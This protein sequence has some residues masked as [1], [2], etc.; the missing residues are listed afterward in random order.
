MGERYMNMALELAL[1]GKCSTSP[2]P[3][4]GAVIVKDG[5]IIGKG[6][7]EKCGGNHAEINAIESATESV[8]GSTI[9]VT[10]EP[11]SHHGK[12]PPCADRIIKEKFAKVVIASLD[13][14]PLVAG[15]G[16]KK[17][18]DA[19]IV[20]ET[21][22]LDEESRTINEVF[23]KYIIEKEPFVLMKGAMSLDGK[24]ATCTGESKWISGEKSREE[25]QELRRFMTGIMVGIGT[26]LAD[27]PELTCRI[28]GAKSPIRIIVDSNLR[29][30]MESKVLK[31]QKQ[32]KTIIASLKEKADSEKINK[33]K[34]IGIEVLLLES[35]SG[36][37]D[38]RELMKELG[39]RE[40]DSI[41]LEGGG[42][43]NFSAIEA[44]IVDKVI[45]YVAPIIIGGDDSKTPVGGQGFIQLKDA[46]KLKEISVSKIGEDIKI[47]GYP[48]RR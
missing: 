15:R 3:M 39:K 29:I 36:K 17:L 47:E 1:K 14:N 26:V 41:L 2:N 5:I 45:M 33:L 18:L 27:D 37:V 9:Y 24:I 38:L 8:E 20:V 19:G 28:P 44:G 34:E 48:E 32:A 22:L 6:Y 23:M 42:T 12:T 16:V 25:V 46:L 10:L 21:G 13:P 40:I 43:L 11:C 30:P 35:K 4:V 7:H 31:N